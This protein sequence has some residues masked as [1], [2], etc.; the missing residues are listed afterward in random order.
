MAGAGKRPTPLQQAFGDRVRGRRRELGLSQEK[1]AEISG[2]DRTYISSL[3]QGLRNV[4]LNN[5][6]RVATALRV[7]CSVLVEGLQE[8]AGHE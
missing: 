6:A 2:L 4:S 1:L 3:E 5:I 8:L 7:D